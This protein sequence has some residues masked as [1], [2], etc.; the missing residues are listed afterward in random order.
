MGNTHTD[1]CRY[2]SGKQA[3]WRCQPCELALCE[4][5][6]PM[7]EL[8]PD[9]VVCPLCAEP[10]ED[11]QVGAMFWQNPKPT[12]L[13]PLHPVH[14]ILI[15][16][17]ALVFGV[18]PAGLPLLACAA[19]VVAV[20]VVA[21]YAVFDQSSRGEPGPAGLHDSLK[22]ERLRGFPDFLWTTMIYALPPALGWLSSSDPLFLALLAAASLVYPA[23]L[24]TMAIEER[25]AAAVDPTRIAAVIATLRKHYIVLAACI[26]ALAVLPGALLL[27]VSN[28]L[29][30][31]VHAGLLALASGYFA[32]LGLGMTGGML[33]QFRRK[34]GFAAGVERIDRPRVP[35]PE[36]YEPALAL[37]DAR[38]QIGEGKPRR[39]R[40]TIGQ[41]LTHHSDHAG[42]NECFDELIRVTGSHSEFRNHVERRLRRLVAVGKAGEAAD[43]WL[44]NREHLDHRLPRS[45]ETCHRMALELEKRGEHHLAVRLLLK[46]PS[47]D[48]R[49][50][51]LPEACLE[52]ARMLECYLDDSAQAARL[53]TW[54]INRF[55]E[56]AR[57]WHRDRKHDARPQSA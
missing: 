19:P 27:P 21:A 5:C 54:I 33:Y 46:L 34:L 9:D 41:A 16:A 24:M 15:S 22:R 18:V 49:Y 42:L 13:Y 29:P 8:L 43:L 10:M 48:P 40:M 6:K 11:L 2:H 30:G 36:E 25:F 57:Q 28:L 56:R 14:L 53:R 47:A 50:P 45:A 51:E 12:L 4:T 35:R 44:N 39:A 32:L 3:R 55:P 37:A 20:F 17:L 31:P 1:R 52:A 23:A 38:I 26:A 7:A